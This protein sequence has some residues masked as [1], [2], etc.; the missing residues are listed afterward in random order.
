M[1]K[2]KI[3][4]YQ[5]ISEY[6]DLWCPYCHCI[7][8]IEFITRPYLKE[9]WWPPIKCWNCQKKYTF[10]ESFYMRNTLTTKVDEPSKLWSHQSRTVYGV[11]VIPPKPEN[12]T[13]DWVNKRR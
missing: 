1:A 7:D 9:T 2:V 8:K 6:W 4:V 10:T 5:T 12:V 11:E 3:N 13:Q